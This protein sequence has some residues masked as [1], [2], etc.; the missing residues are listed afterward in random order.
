MF[1]TDQGVPLM[2]RHFATSDG[3]GN[4]TFECGVIDA[5]LLSVTLIEQDLIITLLLDINSMEVK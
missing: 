4:L 2:K 5:V 1:D 3:S